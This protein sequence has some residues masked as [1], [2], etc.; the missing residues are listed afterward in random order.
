MKFDNTIRKK[1]GHSVVRIFAESINI[2]WKIPY[3]LENPSK[4]Q[5]TGFFIDSKHI[6][7]CCHVVDGAK[8]VYIEIP[9]ISTEKIKCTIVGLCPNFDIA[10]L[11]TES[12]KSKYYLTI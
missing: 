9:D 12:Y 6:I 4:G 3:L 5:G 7:T 1:I 11:K 10:L 8:N 2:N